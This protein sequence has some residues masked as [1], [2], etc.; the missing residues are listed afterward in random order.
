M[1]TTRRKFFNARYLVKRR[2]V[3]NESSETVWPNVKLALTQYYSSPLN[4]HWATNSVMLP[5]S[6]Y[7]SSQNIGYLLTYLDTGTSAVFDCI[8][9]NRDHMVG[10]STAECSKPGVQILRTLGWVLT[11]YQE[12]TIAMYR[13]YNSLTQDHSVSTNSNCTGLGTTEFRVGY[14]FSE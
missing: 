8:I 2:V 1:A 11:S 5:T 10:V 4:D 14:I 3:I 9:A 6:S 7:S 13:C 12:N